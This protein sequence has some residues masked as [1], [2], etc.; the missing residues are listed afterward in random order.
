MGAGK[1]SV[2]QCLSHDLGL[3]AADVDE[4]VVDS[5]GR[6]IAT[7]FAEDGEEAF[8]DLESAALA[9]LAQ[10]YPKLVSCG[11]G[12]VERTENISLMRQHGF[13]VLLDVSAQE[14][15]SRVGGDPDRPLFAEA[16]A[17]RALYER[18]ASLY[19]KAAHIRVA[20]TGH[21][22]EEVAGCVREELVTAGVLH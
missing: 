15:A 9:A 6:T 17:A 11:G 21:T 20:T 22:V 3:P 5:A 18:R 10:S 13:V 1:T 19:E 8:R 14:A 4:V 16:G 7:I 2:A 12:I